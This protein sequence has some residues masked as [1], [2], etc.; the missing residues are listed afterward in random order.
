[1]SVW[2]PAPFF[3]HY[4]IL[5]LKSPTSFPHPSATWGIACSWLFLRVA[6]LR[7]SLRFRSGASRRLYWVPVPGGGGEEDLRQ[8][9]DGGFSVGCFTGIHSFPWQ[10]VFVFPPRVRAGKLSRRSTRGGREGSFCEPAAVQKGKPATVTAAAAAAA[11]ATA[12]AAGK[13]SGD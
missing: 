4:L 12:T 10:L 5:P 13:V 8:D 9:W 1:M 11:A 3:C 7:I 6:S 2:T